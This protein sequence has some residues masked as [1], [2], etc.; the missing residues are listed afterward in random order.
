MRLRLCWFS[1]FLIPSL[2]FG[3]NKDIAEL[4]RDLSQLTDEVRAMRSSSD[5]KFAAMTVLV[6]QILDA[7]NSAKSALAVLDSRMNDKLEKQSVSVSQPVAV[8]SAKVDQMSNDFGG[9]KDALNDVVS[10]I[11]KLDQKLVELNN[12]IR[13]IQAPP[14]APTGPTAGAT[15]PAVP[16]TLF[17]KWHFATKWA[18]SRTWR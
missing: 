17:T 11:G 4:Q 16:Q 10:R 18:V 14:P 5:Q 13:T 15:T 8:I 2:L 7:S 3:V 12:T 9:M 1:L 6:Q